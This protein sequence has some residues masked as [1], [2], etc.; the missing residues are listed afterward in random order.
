MI[1]NFTLERVAPVSREVCLWNTWDHEHLY[2]V[3]NQF[4]SAKMLHEDKTSAVIMT[5]VKM[6]FLPIYMSNLHCLFEKP[7]GDVLVIDTMPLGVTAK[8]LMEYRE[9]QP[10]ATKLTNHYE[11]RLPFFFAPFRS[12]LG[13]MIKKWNDVNWEEDLPLKLR[14][15]KAIDLGFRDFIGIDHR[16][17]GKSQIKLPL[18]RTPNSIIG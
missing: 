4:S 13:R 16:L 7:N 12:I 17:A 10:K 15:Q 18:V 3:H 8:V 11:L 1:F 9:L 2:F 5:R 14:R 6:P